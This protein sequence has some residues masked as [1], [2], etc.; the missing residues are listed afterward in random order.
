MASLLKKKLKT[1]PTRLRRKELIS[2]AIKS[3]GLLMDIKH[4]FTT[5]DLS[6]WLSKT[7][8]EQIRQKDALR[9]GEI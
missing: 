4:I 5:E 1:T 7:I 6:I 8:S 9:L 2:S 3:S